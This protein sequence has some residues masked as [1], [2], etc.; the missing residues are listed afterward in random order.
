MSELC[1]FGKGDR[2]GL[3]IFEGRKAGWHVLLLK[4]NRELWQI[5][6]YECRGTA[7]T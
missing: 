3:L 2:A 4:P 1:L 6:N 5:M 7:G